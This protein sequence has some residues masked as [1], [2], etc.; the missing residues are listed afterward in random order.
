[1]KNYVNDYV[2]DYVDDYVNDHVNDYVNDHVN[3]YVNDHE[4]VIP[5][6]GTKIIM[7]PLTTRSSTHKAPL[8]LIFSTIGTKFH[9]DYESDVKT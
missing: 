1:M 9:V 2:N 7:L 6:I 5:Y 8:E 4:K 3:D